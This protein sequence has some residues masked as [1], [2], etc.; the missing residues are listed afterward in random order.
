MRIGSNCLPLKTLF[1]CLAFTL[2][3]TTT[4]CINLAANLIHAIQ[5]NNRPAEFE[6]LKDH[7]VAIVV[8]TDSGLSVDS[9]SSMIASQIAA[10][11]NSN[12]KKV[13]I[14]RQEEV[15][16][17]LDAHGWTDSD[18]LEIGKGVD[19]QLVLTVDVKKLT[20]KNG[21]TL[22]RGQS[23]I[24]VSVYDVESDG[25]ILYRKQIPEFAFPN[26]GGTPITDTSEAKF[27]GAYLALIARTVS[28]LFYE[29]EATSDFALDATSSRF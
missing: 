19:A 9:S 18:Y 29:V 26:L 27:R 2:L 1:V 4:G 12:I 21:A 7:R 6:G 14:V 23:D 25:K 28:G 17:W 10:T 20:L 24:T 5:G 11:L 15:A 13:D 3:A 16:K 22:Y 8:A